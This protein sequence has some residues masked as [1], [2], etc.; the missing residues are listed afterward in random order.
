MRRRGCTIHS[1]RLPR[2]AGRGTLSAVISIEA[3]TKVFSPLPERLRGRSVRALDC[4]S[5]QLPAGSATALLGPSGAGKSTLLRLLL[6]LARPSSGSVRVDGMAPRAFV[7][8]EGIGYVPERVA[9]P[10]WWTVRGALRAYAMLG[11]LGDDAW[12]R[13]EAEMARFGLTE[14]AGR[15]CGTLSKGTLQR[16]ALAQAVLGRRRILLLDEPTDG[17]DPEWR[18][19]VHAI[20]RQWREEERDRLLLF[21]TH[22]L[23]EAEGLAEHAVLLR[24][25]RLERRLERS[26]APGG[27][28]VRPLGWIEAQLAAPPA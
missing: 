25:G 4:V 16:L 12:E 8:R 1:G 26:G 5:L 11:H 15:R 3:L 20:L 6:G 9:I 28:V 23:Q 10:R 21:T 17:L 14:A 27:Q 22:D 2:E 18:G 19:R 24:D 13:V 7:V